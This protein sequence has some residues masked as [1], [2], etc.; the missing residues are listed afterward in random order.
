MHTD[1]HNTPLNDTMHNTPPFYQDED[2]YT[3]AVEHDTY[4]AST[5]DVESYDEA[6]AVYDAPQSNASR[7]MRLLLLVLVLAMIALFV[8]F[9]AV[10]FVQSFIQP[11]TPNLPPAVQT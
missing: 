6:E 1:T 8:L 2:V 5:D 9:V 7:V 10:P 11:T 4:Y 3:G